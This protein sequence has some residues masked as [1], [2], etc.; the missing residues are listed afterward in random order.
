MPTD[1]KARVP[2][3]DKLVEAISELKVQQGLKGADI[4]I[5]DYAALHR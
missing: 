1:L 2:I 3:G 5:M 4:K